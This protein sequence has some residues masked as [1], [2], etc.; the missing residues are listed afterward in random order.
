MQD[1]TEELGRDLVE[2]GFTSTVVST[3]HLPDLKAGLECL[4]EQGQLGRVFYD[5]IV[6][7]YGLEFQFEG[8]PDFPEAQSIIITAAPQPK[9]AAKFKLGDTVCTAVVPPTYVHDTD[10]V[11]LDVI[12]KHLQPGG[13]R[14]VTALL[15]SKLLS[16]YA[17][18][19][20]Y[21]RNNI[22]YIEGMGSYF[23]LRAFFSDTPCPSDQWQ[24]L[25]MMDRCADCIVCRKKCP[26]DVITE[27][28]FLIDASRCITYH[29]EGDDEFPEWIRPEWHNCVIGCMICQD[30]CPANREFK[31]WI[32]KGP[33][34]S[35]E[36]T[37]MVLDADSL[38]NLPPG[39][40]K[41]LKAYGLFHDGQLPRNLRA[42]MDKAGNHL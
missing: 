25:K 11:A 21:G 12:T 2:A 23:R 19:A 14:A 29:N 15:P 41:Q 32:V 24:E 10:M 35:E 4:L 40:I 42:L 16:V 31:D 27:D 8:P 20:T 36:E 30:V 28:R 39:I 26:A 13:F 34:F 37:R 9:I 22:A 38:E 18:L 33:E 7:R 17:G 6:S 5:D 3:R 1:M